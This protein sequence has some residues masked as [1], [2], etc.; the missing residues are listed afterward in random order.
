MS[1]EI[2]VGDISISCFDSITNVIE[3]AI[4]DEEKI[5]PGVAIAIN[6]EKIVSARNNLKVREVINKATL[7][8]PDGIGVSYVMSKKLGE[9]VARI[10]GCELWEKLMYASVQ[11]QLPV[12]LVG[13][14][15]EV[16]SMTRKKLE[17][18]GVNVVGIQD[19]Y[20]EE[21]KADEVIRDIK[22]TGAKIVTV[23]LGSPKQELFI[24][25]CVNHIPD[26]FYM[27]VGGTYDVY[28]GNVQRAPKIYRTLNIEWLY[29]LLSQPTR[30]G[31]QVNLLKYIYYYLSKRL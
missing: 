29:R 22:S 6:P 15:N 24:Y 14:S 10:P 19:G 21:N 26:A 25:D 13:A 28:I 17:D 27:G 7:R 23:A 5:I 1:K 4:L 12:Y 16:I 2:T 31:R 20:F 9:K 8:Y 11:H 18:N 3:S 30:I